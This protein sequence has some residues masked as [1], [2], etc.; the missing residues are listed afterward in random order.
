MYAACG[1]QGP[2]ADMTFE[3]VRDAFNI[4]RMLPALILSAASAAA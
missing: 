3:G 2:P 4:V 1:T